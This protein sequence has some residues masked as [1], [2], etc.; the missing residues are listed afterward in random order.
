MVDCGVMGRQRRFEPSWLRLY[1][2]HMFNGAGQLLLVVYLA[3]CMGARVDCV[4][5]GSFR[6]GVCACYV[7]VNCIG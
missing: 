4:I 1:G 7:F 5:S 6:I 3:E 2:V